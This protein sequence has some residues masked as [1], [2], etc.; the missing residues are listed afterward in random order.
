M[1]NADTLPIRLVLGYQSHRA[2]AIFQD[3][4][5]CRHSRFAASLFVS[6]HQKTKSYAG[7]RD[8][9]AG[10]GWRMAA[11]SAA[12]ILRALRAGAN[13]AKAVVLARFFK[14]GPGQYG[15]GDRFWGLTVPV[16]RKVVKA[17]RG[18]PLD[19]VEKLLGHAVHEVRLAACLL[20]VDAYQSATTDVARSAIFTF[21]LDHAHRINNW[22]LVDTSAPQIVGAHLLAGSADMGLLDA[23]AASPVI[24]SRRIG[25]LATFTFIRAGNNDPTFRLCA[26]LLSDPEDLMHKACGWMLRETGKRGGLAGLR[27]FLSRHHQVMPR[28]ML[29][30]AIE[31]MEA[32]ERVRWMAKDNRAR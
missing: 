18:L 8:G 3:T 6:G 28:T 21:Y 31:H 27:K 17:H 15:A 29:R 4:H 11:H 25:V 16:V 30:Y 12:S 9:L 20:L 1:K 14:S 7:L 13:P 26:A 2:N 24:W 10:L 23:L 32:E 5:P 22:D 19:E